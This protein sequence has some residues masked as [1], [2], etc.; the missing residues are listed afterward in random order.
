VTDE[1]RYL[2][3]ARVDYNDARRY[4]LARGWVRADIPRMDIGVFHLGEHEAILPM[5]TALRDYAGA[6]VRFARRLGDVE[7][8]SHDKV[9][10]DLV[11]ARV[12]RH[13]PA[14]TGANDASLEA[15]MSLLDGIQ[16]ALLAS[17]CSVLHPRPYHPRMSL[18]QAE[19]LLR[20]TRFTGTEI[21]SFVAVIETPL[22]VEHARPG[23]GRDVSSTLMRSLAHIASA[24]RSGV[25]DRI[26]NPRDEDP[27]VSANL[28]EAILRMA[29]PSEASDLRFEI[30]W[31][32]ML[33]APPG[34]PDRISID[35]TMYEPL[36]QAA[37]QLR[38]SPSTSRALHLSL[39]KELKGSINPDGKPEGEATFVVLRDDG[40]EVRAKAYLDA[41]LYQI[42][43]MAHASSRP[44]IVD[45]ELHGVRRSFELRNLTTIA[46]WTPPGR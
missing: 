34:V 30:S 41:T 23:F 6:M 32:P 13:R 42:A 44:V 21:G 11:S 18:S 17:A 2:L 5:D 1:E 8:R 10:Q 20:A 12:D 4:A 36:E 46:L 33:A 25:P 19:E 38:P 27:Q 14:R 7:G 28:C 37:S 3:A 45:A 26:V 24:I 9:L 31:S 16:R 40:R 43:V 35:R 39:V 15:A 22:E 29:P